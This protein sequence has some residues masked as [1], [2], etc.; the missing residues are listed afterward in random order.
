MLEGFSEEHDPLLGQEVEI[1]SAAGIAYRG[2][3]N[4]I[5]AR[6]NAE[7]FVLGSARDAGFQRIVFVTDRRSQIRPVEAEV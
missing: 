3:V 2:I 4:T 7:L 1:S 6:G 5:R